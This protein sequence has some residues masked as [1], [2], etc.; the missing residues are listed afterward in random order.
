MFTEACLAIGAVACWVL[1]V[2][3]VK[4]AFRVAYRSR[5]SGTLAPVPGPEGHWFWGLA[6]ELAKKRRVRLDWFTEML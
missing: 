4:I 2:T 3:A 1:L 5:T 6:P